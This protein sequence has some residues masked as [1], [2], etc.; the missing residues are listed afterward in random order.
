VGFEAVDKEGRGASTGAEAA[1]ESD[2][3][4]SGTGVFSMR[5]SPGELAEIRRAAELQGVPVS[6][7]IRAAIRSY[8]SPGQ[9]S[10][11]SVSFGSMQGA[12]AQLSSALP[13]WS[14]GRM[15]T[16]PEVAFDPRRHD[17]Y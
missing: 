3:K 1:S 2:R 4:Q 17:A 10:W 14:G 15:V 7:V 9:F 8:L 16:T 5:F 6:D 13:I 11:A 12:G